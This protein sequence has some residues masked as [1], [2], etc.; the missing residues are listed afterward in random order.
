MSESVPVSRIIFGKNSF[1]NVV[2]VQ[3][4]QF[5]PADSNQSPNI[6]TEVADFFTSYNTI[7]YDIP[8]TG[9]FK[10]HLELVNRSSEYLG[11]S[12]TD[13]NTEIQNLRSENVSLKQQLY[14]LTNK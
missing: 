5:V 11:I 2:D 12:F 3:F 9:S 8:T 14:T 10:S 4:K 13:L 6:I 7:F 1:Q